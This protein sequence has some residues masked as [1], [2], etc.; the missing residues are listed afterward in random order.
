LL[1]TLAASPGISSDNLRE[2]LARLDRAATAFKAMTA[3]VTYVNH[4]DVLSDDST[5]EGAVV[6]QKVQAGE[7]Q[8]RVDF[9]AP[10]PKTVTFEKRRFQIY[11][12]KIKTLQ[13]YDLDKHGEQLDKFVMIGFGTAG[14]ELAR[15]Y[16]ATVLGTE[17]L[18]MPGQ[19]DVSAIR[20]QLIPKSGDARQY[21]KKLELWIPEQGDPYP[22]REKISQPSGDYRLVTYTNLKI[23]PG[24]KSDALQLKLPPG[25]KTEYPQK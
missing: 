15:D 21:V 23:N 7:V 19:P 24:L 1:L 17:A 4:I 8:G 10:D 22:L 12:P 9:T 20:L 25:V 3:Q 13:V 14:T 16:D 11:F 2:L 18:K 6:M 5:E